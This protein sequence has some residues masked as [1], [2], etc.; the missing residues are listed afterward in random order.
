MAF[1]FAILKR[2]KP[3]YMQFISWK[4]H[5]KSRSE[6]TLAVQFLI[7]DNFSHNTSRTVTD[8]HDI[9]SGSQVVN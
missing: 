3:H 1:S 7:L 6:A 5:C 9:N 2:N 4:N 8:S